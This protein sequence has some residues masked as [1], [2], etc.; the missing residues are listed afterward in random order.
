MKHF[1]LIAIILFALESKAQTTIY[2]TYQPEMEAAYVQ[3]PD[4]PKGILEAI[5]FT[6]THFSHI[7]DDT[8]ESCFGLPHAYGVMGL[9]E[10]GQGYFKNNLSLVSRLS[11]NSQDDIKTSPYISVSAYAGAYQ[12][13]MDSLQISSVENQIKIIQILSEIP[14]DNNVTNN[15]ALDCHAYSIYTFLNSTNNQQA[16]NFPNYNI[17]LE[18]I[19]GANNLAVLSSSENTFDHTGISNPSGLQYSVQ[20]NRTAEYGPALWV[21]TPTCNYSSRNGTAISA[22]TIHT[23]QGSYA[24]AISWAQ[25]C[26]AN[27]SYHY[28]VRSSDGQI[29]QM[30][31]EADKGWHVGAENPYTIGIEHDGYVSDPS[32]YTTALYTASADLC[33]DITQSGYGI[34]P[35]RT[36]FGDATTGVN[37]LGGCTKIKG[38]QHYPNNT[39]TDPGVNWDWEGFYKLINNNPSYTT[40]TAGS[41]NLYDSGGS[42][43]NYTDDER[44]LYL[45][46]PTSS[47]TVTVTFNSFDIEQDWDYL[48]IYDGA[49]P[50]APLIGKYTGTTSPGTITSTGA[51]LLLEFRS[52]CAT[53]APGWALTYTSTQ[54]DNTPPTTSISTI[55]PWQTA[56]F[57]ATFTDA[58]NVGVTEAY[59]QVADFDGTEWR[60]NASYGFFNDEFD[61]TT[62]NTDWTNQLGTWNSTPGYLQQTDE[63]EGNSNLYASLTQDASSTYIYNWQGQING[64]GTNR[65]AGLHFFCDDP[66]QTQR[67]NSYM[68]YWRV[69]Q[70]KCQI[71]EVNANSITLMTDD[72]IVVDPNIWYDFKIV[73]DPASGNIKAFLDNN[74]VSQWTDSTP[75][76]TGNS[77]STRTGNCIGV[78]DD[79]RVYKSRTASELI[80]IGNASS[81]FRYQNPNPS[82]P[83]GRIAS[84]AID[85]NLNWSTVD[86]KLENID[87]TSPST[88]LT[89]NDGIASDID[90][91]NIGTE[92]IANWTNSTDTH[93]NVTAYWY[94][95]GTTAG[96]TDVVNWTNNGTATTVTHTG[97]SLIANQLYYYSV[98]SEN[99]AGLESVAL[100]SD[101]QRYVIPSTPPVSNFTTSNTTLCAGENM[102]LTNSSSDATSYVWNTTG[103]TLSSTTATNPT[104]A[105]TTSGSYTIDLTANG[106][107]GTDNSSQTI[108]VIIV[109]TPIANATPSTTTVT[110]PSGSVTF[111]NTSSD[112]TSY[113]WDF[114]DGNTSTSTSPTNNYTTS[115]TYTVMLIAS[116]GTCT[117][118]TTYFT[119]TVNDTTPVAG[120]STSN[121]TICAGQEIQL[122][123]NSTSA[124]SY[125]WNTTG[126]TLSSTTASDPTIAFATSGSYTIDLTAT[127]TGGTD[128]SSQTITVTVIQAPVATATPSATTVTLPAST[129]N[130]TNSSTNATSYFWDFDDGNSSTLS[131]PSNTYTTS[132][133]YTVMMIASNSTCGNDTTYFTITVLDAPTPPVS[134][135]STS[136]TTICAG[137]NIQLSNNSTNATSYLWSTTG[138][139]LSSTT[140]TN[141][142]IAFT[143][144]GNYTI[145]LTA[146]G[147]GG[148]DVSSQIIN[149]T[150][151]Q[152]PVASATPNATS[153][154]L[155]AATINFTNTSTD[156]T[157]YFWDF[158][159]GNTST[160]ASASNTYTVS[161]IYTVMLIASNG[162]CADD[163]TYFTIT[164]I[165]P[166]TPPVATFSASNTTICLGDDIQ[167]T[168]NSTDANSYLWNTTG[169]TLSSTT[170]T[171]PT[172]AFSTTGSYTV[173]LTAT[174]P[175]G[176]DNSSQSISVT[177]VQPPVANATPSATTV[178]L[179]SGFVSFS[180]TSTN[181]T[182]YFWNFGDG[183]TSTTTSPSNSYTTSGTY[184]AMLIASNGTCADDTT[185]STITVLDAPTP[186][187]AIFTTS[188]T[189]ICAG[190]TIQL[191]NGSTDATSYLWNTN[192]GTLSS[193]TASD[194]TISFTASGSYTI[195]L[196]ATGPGGTDNSNQTISVN[197]VQAPIA[198]GTP[199]ATTVTLPFGSVTFTNTSSNATSYFWYYGDGNTSTGVSP[200]NAYTVSGTYTAM[201][202]ASNGTCPNDTSYFT[203]QVLDAETPPI[204]QFS[205]SNTTICQGE[206]LQ[207]NNSSTDA[208]SYLWTSTGGTFSSSI[209]SD[210]TITFSNSG[211]YT[212]DLEATGPGGT[213]MSSQTITVTLVPAPIAG[214][215]PN[216]DTVYLPNG[217]VSF[218]NQ[219]FNSSSYFWDFGDGNTS[220]DAN[221]WNNYTVAGDYDVLLI[222]SSGTCPNDTLVTPI[223]VVGYEGIENYNTIENINIYPNPVL[224]E[225]NISFYSSNNKTILIEIIDITGRKIGN[226]YNQNLGQGK[227]NLKI[228]ITK[229]NL[230]TG[231]YQLVISNENQKYTSSFIVQ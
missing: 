62:L 97:L 153:F 128:N 95:I 106:P 4:I 174:G 24:G 26:S 150:V 1:Y 36:F 16:Y 18:Q 131:S 169:G 102:Q 136:G 37:V 65:R 152:T 137:D 27:V 181:A 112:A 30:L 155:P 74:L 214:A 209:A 227:Q 32:W 6:T 154:T 123:N 190:S 94:A 119:I 71:Y 166:A 159:D 212:I 192:G 141:P 173:D 56:D 13:L 165:D 3:Y 140:A 179:P 78:Y 216:A 164:V 117:D 124:I 35:L 139:T 129:I 133:T 115:G 228:D 2:N 91:T 84:L 167:L 199:S 63:A 142:T 12:Y 67:G 39:H 61:Q 151:V 180:N 76:T 88:V 59:Y 17:D 144:S 158:G 226:V 50:N 161:G 108:N 92:L 125:I 82:T 43:G 135:F 66:T 60:S 195:D 101:G 203:I 122:T 210:P 21:A 11:G 46:Q 202:V 53:T 22:V 184:T 198:S 100:D 147:T 156:A 19:F 69:D 170:A 145:D 29:T 25:N 104:I 205:T 40:Y 48:F 81:E 172:I 219:S 224:S 90:T 213:N 64:T 197:V 132:G 109:Q 182:S 208:T 70:D 87:W 42:T 196:T 191:S 85:A 217:L 231:M 98:K 134:I 175:G 130:F 79:F 149:I 222:A 45:I 75:L 10:D 127:G 103:G 38:H 52:D 118:D 55:N 77:I 83:S 41:G 7:S 160:I 111:T 230:S 189:T 15:Y 188:S 51:D 68:V 47:S 58:D 8:P 223:V 185:Y 114:G 143:S 72:D 89:I 207:L 221:P 225:L 73:Y 5:S 157:S 168:N 107:G 171:N 187:V 186:P 183:N 105:F 99:G 54:A 220:T 211:N 49:T 200:T 110:L 28:V 178:T 93:S 80:T 126:G 194:P 20:T 113:Y 218:T 34:N 229:Y 162:T 23:I 86:E 116:N 14:Q 148:S 31:L 201:L 138:G 44:L 206:S 193:T 96:A 176:T 177:V 204:S 9:I 121:T 146:T 120:F 33:R 57:T 215:F 163:T